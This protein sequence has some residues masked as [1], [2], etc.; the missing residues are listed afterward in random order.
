MNNEETAC[1]YCGC[2]DI[3]VGKQAAVVIPEK[4]MTVFNGQTL[5]HDICRQCGTVVRSYIKDP[6]KFAAKKR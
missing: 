1:P 3:I 6:E 4:E 5:Y 2:T